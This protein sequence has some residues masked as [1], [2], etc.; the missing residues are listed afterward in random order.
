[1]RRGLW[2]V[3]SARIELCHPHSQ[4]NA[5]RRRCF[6]R[7]L[8]MVDRSGQSFY[9]DNQVQEC[10]RRAPGRDNSRPG[11]YCSSRLPRGG[12][13]RM[14]ILR[15]DF[16]P[17]P[18]RTATQAAVGSHQDFPRLKPTSPEAHSSH[19]R[20]PLGAD[21]CEDSTAVWKGTY[22]LDH[23][24]AGTTR[25]EDLCWAERARRTVG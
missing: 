9:D 11:A 17:G 19:R 24:I 15:P 5:P 3:S 2:S 16:R 8:V 14:S 7:L 22:A 20:A 13:R 6:D 12:R 1:M 10:T 18:L 21:S 23:A 4:G 25:I